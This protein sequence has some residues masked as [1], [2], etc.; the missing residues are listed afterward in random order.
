MESIF[1]LAQFALKVVLIVCLPFS[2]YLCMRIGKTQKRPLTSM[3]LQ[4]NDGIIKIPLQ[5]GKENLI[6]RQSI[7]PE[8]PHI[9]RWQLVVTEEKGIWRFYNVGKSGTQLNGHTQHEGVLMVGDTL[10][11]CGLIFVLMPKGGSEG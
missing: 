10:N 5:A 2:V 7:A 3:E 9:S 8:N 11:I 1:W 4:S 6:G